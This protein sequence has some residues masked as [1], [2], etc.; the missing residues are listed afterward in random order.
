V[1]D[2]PQGLALDQAS[3]RLYVADTGNRVIRLV[4]FDT[5]RITTVAGSGGELTSPVAVAVAPD[6]RLYVAD[7][8]ANV[9][10]LLKPQS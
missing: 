3:R 5:G 7:A 1:L 2:D 4:D 10:R 8:G 6:G 9:I